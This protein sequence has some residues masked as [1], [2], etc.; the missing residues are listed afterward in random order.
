MLET[1]RARSLPFPVS[2]V[3]LTPQETNFYLIRG[4]PFNVGQPAQTPLTGFNGPL[5]PL[6]S[7]I[8]KQPCMVPPMEFCPGTVCPPLSVPTAQGCLQPVLR[9][10]GKRTFQIPPS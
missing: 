3:S 9:E 10:H 6:A 5:L 7:E 4:K 8:P 1:S 2:H